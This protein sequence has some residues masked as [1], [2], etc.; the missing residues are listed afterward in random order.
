MSIS[1]SE[2][3]IY[4][5]ISSLSDAR[6]SVD[7]SLSGLDQAA[8]LIKEKV[9]LLRM[10]GES[11]H[12]KIQT[13]IS[14]ANY[15]RTCNNSYMSSLKD[16]LSDINT[17]ISNAASDNER[18][19]LKK[20]KDRIQN[21]MDYV[22]KANKALD[23]LIY[24]L[25]NKQES[26][27]KALIS[28]REVES[29][30]NAVLS[31][32][33]KAINNLNSGLDSVSR[34]AENAKVYVHRINECLSDVSN[35]TASESKMINIKG[36]N[37]LFNMASSLS[38]TYQAIGDGNSDYANII[39]SFTTMIQDEVS[40]SVARSGQDMINKFQMEL[41]SFPDYSMKFKNAGQALAS[42]ESLK[43]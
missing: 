5:F 29:N 28:L 7:S 33:S 38:S 27:Y 25:Q 41:K 20:S 39:T 18:A 11:A 6:N 16:Q 24:K 10:A 13:L 15:A 31:N 37:Y 30:V 14:N 9:N 42:Y 19:A 2:A 4:Q 32:K 3:Q 1:C 36:P 35:S 26:L 8:D 23:D 22:Y 43:L 34:G 40:K 21:S 17:S 12:S